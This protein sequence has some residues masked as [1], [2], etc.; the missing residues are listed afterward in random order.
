LKNRLARPV[1]LRAMAIWALFP[2]LAV[3]NGIARDWLLAPRLGPE[4]AL[5]FSGVVLCVVILGVTSLLIGRLGR[6][7]AAQYALVG[8]LW[9]GATI[10]FETLLGRY[11]I[12]VSWR[13]LVSAYDPRSGNL[14]LLV[15]VT[16]TA[17]P[18]FGARLRGLI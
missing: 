13:S 4:L 12:G 14:W 7:T 6:L 17:A 1:I 15:L 8:A 10:A 2:P 5:P 3:A 11:A 18:Y 9:L 16:T